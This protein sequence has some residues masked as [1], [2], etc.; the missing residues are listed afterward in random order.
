MNRAPQPGRFYYRLTD[1]IRITV[2]PRYVAEES[3]PARRRFV[4]IYA[5]RIEN[6]GTAPARLVSRRWRIHDSIGLDTTVEGEGVLGQQPMIPPGGVHEYES[7]CELRSPAGHMEGEYRFVRSDGTAFD[8]AI[9]RF[10]LEAA[11]R[12]P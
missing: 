3:R 2:R 4:F 6:V 5:V 8:A 1:G 12:L 11:D 7:F 10:A 9:P